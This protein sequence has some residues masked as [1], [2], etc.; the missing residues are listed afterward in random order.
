MIEPQFHASRPNTAHLPQRP[1]AP[2]RTVLDEEI[3]ILRERGLS[4][5]CIHGLLSGFNIDARFEPSEDHW[6]TV[7]NE[8]LIRLI[9]GR[10]VPLH[11]HAD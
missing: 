4:D 11:A 1:S 2:S 10:P 5:D 6:K 7:V 3:R 9:W 8:Q